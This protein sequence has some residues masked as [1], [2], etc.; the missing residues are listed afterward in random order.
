MLRLSVSA[1][2][3]AEHLL[4]AVEIRIGKLLTNFAP[5]DMM[6]VLNLRGLLWIGEPFRVASIPT[7]HTLW[8]VGNRFLERRLLLLRRIGSVRRRLR[9]L[10]AVQRPCGFHFPQP[11]TQGMPGRSV[12]WTFRLGHFRRL[13]VRNR[14]GQF[15]SPRRWRSDRR[16]VLAR[17]CF[18][19]T[20]VAFPD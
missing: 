13:R 7:L 19:T 5:C 17:T 20:L 14:I 16:P 4:H 2:R 1:W 10:A 3:K 12:D 15:R 18:D 11:I 9:R 6:H 8:Q